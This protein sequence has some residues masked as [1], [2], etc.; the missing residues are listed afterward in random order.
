[1]KVYKKC[2]DIERRD[3]IPVQLVICVKRSCIDMRYAIIWW[4]L[5][6]TMRVRPSFTRM[7]LSGLDGGGKGCKQTKPSTTTTIHVRT[8][9][10]KMWKQ[11]RCVWHWLCFGPTW[12]YG[13]SYWEN[14]DAGNARVLLL[15]NW[16]TCDLDFLVLCNLRHVNIYMQILSMNYKLY[17]VFHEVLENH[18]HILSAMRKLILGIFNQIIGQFQYLQKVLKTMTIPP[19]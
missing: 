2:I 17:K 10:G 7:K 1:M 3:D 12:W 18:Q 6:C 9:R 16:Q 4:L 8:V 11:V 5:L 14:D 15:T 13:H 19:K